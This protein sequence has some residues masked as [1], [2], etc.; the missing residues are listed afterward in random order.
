MVDFPW[1]NISNEKTV[2]VLIAAYFALLELDS[3]EN[4]IIAQ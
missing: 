1:W 3:T 4:R 2:F